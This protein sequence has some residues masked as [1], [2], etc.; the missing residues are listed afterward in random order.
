MQPDLNGVTVA[1][2]GGDARET[3]LAERLAALG[4]TVRVVGLPV[5]KKEN[6]ILCR[7]PAEGLEGVDAVIL[8]VPGINDQGRLY[9]AYPDRPLI[10][11]EEMLASLSPGTPV[12]V[13]V[14]KP[15]LKKM[16]AGAGVTLIEIMEIDEV[17]ILNSIPSAEGAVQ[18]AM[19]KTPITIHGS[20]SVVLGFGRTAVTLARM[21]KALGAK[22]T[23][24]ARNTA[25]RA[26]AAEMGLEAVDFAALPGVL[27]SAEIIFNTVPF[28]V[29]D[30]EVLN[31]IPREAL[32]I[33]IASVPG[34]TDF[35]AAKKLGLTAI[36]ALGLPGK[37]APKTAGNILAGVVPRLLAERLARKL[38]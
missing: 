31:L 25:A 7:N 32:I 8:P 16:A 37:V 21:L 20:K 15:L 22:T 30:E 38:N 23:V 27:G 10:L 4:A 14:A 33:D 17:A 13:G 9:T 28:M 12:F 29:L 19:E 34:G 11:S 18:I 1:V 2:L 26:R 3:I 36:H 5:N 35:S 24:V 6:I